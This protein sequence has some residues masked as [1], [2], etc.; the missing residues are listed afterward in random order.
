MQC[1]YTYTHIR[2]QTYSNRIRLHRPEMAS[3]NAPE[4]AV[5]RLKEILV[6]QTR[7]K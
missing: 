1:T 2:V 4:I 5:A 7:R 6:K 3:L